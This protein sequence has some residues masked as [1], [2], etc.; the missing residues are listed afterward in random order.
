VSTGERYV[1]IG[2]AHVRSVWFRDLA[3]WATSAAVPCEFVKCVSIEE[4]RA[5]LASGRTFSA[6]IVD[7]SMPGVDRDLVD[8]ARR[9]SCAV[10]VVDD[11]RVQRDW[12]GLGAS[13]LLETG[14]DRV[15]LVSAL[16]AN[17]RPVGRHD[18]PFEARHPEPPP[19]P[20]RA[21]LVAVTGPGGTGASVVAMAIA[22][23]LADDPLDAGMVLLADLALHA[24]QAMLHDARDVVP[25]VLELVDAHRAGQPTPDEI[26]AL[27]FDVANRRYHLLLGLRRHRD[28]AALRP[29]AVE[30]ALLG[31]RGSYR[32]VV[33]DIDS[34][35]EGERDC[36]SV[37]VEERNVLAR[38]AASRADIVAVVGK[39][40]PKGIHALARTV[41]ELLAVVEPQRVLPVVTN[42]PRSPR[43][44]AEISRALAALVPAGN[45]AAPVSPA[46]FVPE[47][48]HLDDTIRD[49]ARLPAAATRPITTAVRSLLE[50]VATVPA[51][52]AEADGPRRLEPGELGAW[53]R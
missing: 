40:G 10:L 45:D 23:G 48:R 26:R 24:D 41:R 1:V 21:P 17:A 44:R 4:V 35:V 27:A 28:W 2:L 8:V 52:A 43:R 31:M 32:F 22:Q 46:L 12:E 30:A 33:A 37:E 47:W 14:F 5:R 11:G 36:G 38:A 42:A 3:R 29:R 51:P 50:R 34:D 53:A 16:H 39:P 13:A 15:D 20:W 18:V 9:H 25:G 6:L 7:G 19:A 49:G